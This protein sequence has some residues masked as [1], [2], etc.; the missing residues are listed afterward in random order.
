LAT[1]ADEVTRERIQVS[2]GGWWLGW[3]SATIA[4][5]GYPPPRRPLSTT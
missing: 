2:C 5:A 3:L 4:R 1:R